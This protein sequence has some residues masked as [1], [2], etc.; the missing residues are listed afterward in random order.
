MSHE[1]HLFVCK[2]E[3]VELTGQYFVAVVNIH[4]H[5]IPRALPQLRT[6]LSMM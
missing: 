2:T 1:A 5:A 4:R 3:N 6:L